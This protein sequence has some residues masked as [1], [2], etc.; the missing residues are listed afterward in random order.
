MLAPQYFVN[1]TTLNAQYLPLL[2]QGSKN[3]CCAPYGR[4]S[5]ASTLAKSSFQFVF[6]LNT[7]NRS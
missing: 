6:Q 5:M 1:I 3:K 7:L 4:I 2:L